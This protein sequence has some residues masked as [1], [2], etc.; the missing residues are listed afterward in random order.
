[1]TNRRAFLKDL[2]GV[3]PADAAVPAVGCLAQEP[4]ASGIE[5]VIGR[6]YFGELGVEPFIKALAPYSS[7]I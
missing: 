5:T 3:V 2:L 4:A 1:M 6:N 7:P